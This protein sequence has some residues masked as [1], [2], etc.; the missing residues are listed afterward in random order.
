M[1][2]LKSGVRIFVSAPE[3]PFA[4][5]ALLAEAPVFK[6]KEM[7]LWVYF[8]RLALLGGLLAYFKI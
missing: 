5:R 8:M 2:A 4:K 3:V 1:L 7:A 6:C